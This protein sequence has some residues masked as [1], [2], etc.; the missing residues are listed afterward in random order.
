[1]LYLLDTDICIYLLNGGNALLRKRFVNCRA[2]DLGVSA[3]T[4]AELLYGALHSARPTPNRD[5]VRAFVAPLEVC[6]FDSLAARH[7]AELKQAVTSKGRPGG[8]MDLL[9]AAVARSR[10]LTI[11]T[12]NTRHFAPIPGLS[13][14]NWAQ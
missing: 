12:N 1:M 13:V 4:E 2:E 8:I 14:E 6:P 3:I 10:G 9:I 5:R 7:F 11:V